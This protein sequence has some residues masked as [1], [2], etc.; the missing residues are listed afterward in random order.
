MS[1]AS[2]NRPD[3][4]SPAR[5][6][7]LYA[8][9]PWTHMAMFPGAMLHYADLPGGEWGLTEFAPRVI[10]LTHGL[11]AAEARSTLAH[12]LV[13]LERGPLPARAPRRVREVE[14]TVCD[15]IAALR[16]IPAAR[17]VTLGEQIERHGELA[18]AAALEVDEFLVQ[19]AARVSAALRL[20]TLS[21]L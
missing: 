19:A 12:E 1:I 3:S 5:G 11:S 13:H 20:P 14:E 6:R 7:V 4:L 8:Y 10:T 18:V 17:L 16:L 2:T 15:T 21:A 9:D